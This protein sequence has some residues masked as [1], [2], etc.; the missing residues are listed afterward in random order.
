MSEEKAGVQ[1]IGIHEGLVVGQAVIAELAVGV[2]DD[3]EFLHRVIGCCAGMIATAYHSIAAE[4][5]QEL[6]DRWMCLFVNETRRML[7]HTYGKETSRI[8]TSRVEPPSG[9]C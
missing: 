2:V 6:A 5:G 3:C 1:G 9:K 8:F 7:G 4:K